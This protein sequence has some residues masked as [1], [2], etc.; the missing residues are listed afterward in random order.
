MAEYVTIPLDIEGVK[1]NRVEVTGNGE[2]HI[3]V[4]STVDGTQCHR[5]GRDIHRR[6]DEGREIKL[7]HLPILD[8]P[9]Y[10]FL[11]PP[12][13]ICDDCPGNPTTTQHLPWYE[14]GHAVTKAYAEHVLKLLV[15]STVQDV[16]EKEKIGYD[17]V[18]GIV[19]GQFGQG[20]DWSSF[21]SLP[22]LGVDD[23][24]LK[25]G[26][27]DFA[28]IVSVRTEDGENRLLG[29]LENREKA[30]VKAFLMSIPKHLRDTVQS[31]CSDLYEGYTEAAREV[32][33]DKVVIV[34]DR[35]HVA[36]LYRKEVG[37]VRKKE[38][39]RLKRE[40]S[41]EEYKKLKGSMWLVRKGPD[42][43]GEED[44]ATLRL[45]FGYAPA[46]FPAYAFGWAL[47]G[48]FDTP[49]TKTR[50]EEMLRAWMRLARET[51]VE[52]FYKFMNT[53]DE[54]MDLITNYFIRRQNS[55]FVEGLNHKIRVLLGR[56]YG[57]FNR[58]HLFQRLSLDL[59]GYE[60]FA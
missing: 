40:L 58:I 52:G 20:V 46:L 53:L 24:A 60:Q 2:V 21:S 9:T 33:G 34:A 31:V 17:E 56:C 30:T 22:T 19:E 48:I 32:F 14:P 26:H 29:I 39:R 51:K 41:E 49:Q 23:L 37:T 6:Y 4:S 45:L 12:R 38:M 27:R 1:V 28:T 3:H 42:T 25:K 44:R 47:T 18:E 10:I 50:A 35:F 7:R 8:M 11:K 55:G 16:S 59:G 43:L 5:C 54:K 13:Y 36:K 57:V 15:N